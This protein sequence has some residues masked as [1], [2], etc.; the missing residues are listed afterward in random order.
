MK[1]YLVK[2]RIPDAG[3][4]V[5]PD[6]CAGGDYYRDEYGQH[7]VYARNAAQARR[8]VQEVHGQNA[9]VQS[10]LIIAAGGDQ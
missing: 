1:H 9:K 7:I 3:G 6:P 5:P 10:P 2:F 4:Y 8:I